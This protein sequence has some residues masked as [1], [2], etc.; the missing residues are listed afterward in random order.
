MLA[1][2]TELGQSQRGLSIGHA[3]LWR[4]RTLDSMRRSYGDSVKPRL[5]SY[6]LYSWLTRSNGRRRGSHGRLL[7]CRFS[8][9]YSMISFLDCYHIS[10]LRTR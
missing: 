7:P 6:T 1:A 10:L 9:L 2:R 5:I 8:K 3:I 4:S